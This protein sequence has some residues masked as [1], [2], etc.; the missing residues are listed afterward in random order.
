MFGNRT[1]AIKIRTKPVILTARNRYASPRSAVKKREERFDIQ[2]LQQPSAPTVWCRSTAYGAA[3]R[4]AA[5]CK[6]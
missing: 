4:M 6:T 2:V 5:A 1:E 3:A